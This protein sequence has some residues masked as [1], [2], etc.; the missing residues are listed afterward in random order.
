[1]EKLGTPEGWQERA[2]AAG[3][4]GPEN[5]KKHS[6]VWGEL[7]EPLKALSHGKCFYCEIVQERS[8]GAVDHFRPKKMYPW[9]AFSRANFRFA[10][11][12]CNSRRTDEANERT[13]GKGDYFPLFD[14]A[15]RATC[16][17][18][19]EKESPLL[20]DPCN[21]NEPGLIDFD[22]TGAPVPSYSAEEHEGRH[23]RADVSIR[24][25]HLDHSDLIDRR[26]A[27]AVSI[28][29]KVKAADRI[30]AFTEAGNADIDAS[31]L[32]H[33]RFLAD[34]INE[35]AELSVFARRILEGYRDRL[36]VEGLLRS[37]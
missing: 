21:P 8:D 9:S 1:M 20:L 13:G 3:A 4:D 22:E 12:F 10:C 31:F 19:E 36:W 35:R 32:E 16:L 25:Y 23:K 2:A 5:I 33:I 6:S 30:F 17:I 18:E 11:T 27:L 7:K 15:T 28:G 24:L 34:C 26:K 29:R 37:A 14:E